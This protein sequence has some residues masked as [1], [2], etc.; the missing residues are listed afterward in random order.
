MSRPSFL[1]IGA[2]YDQIQ[3][4]FKNIVP[5]Q[6]ATL[7]S[8]LSLPPTATG[9]SAPFD[10]F[11]IISRLRREGTL[12]SNGILEELKLPGTG[13]LHG[14]SDDAVP[15][16][17]SLSKRQPEGNGPVPTC[18]LEEP[19]FPKDGTSD[20][21]SSRNAKPNPISPGG[22]VSRGISDG[23]SCATALNSIQKSDSTVRALNAAVLI[24]KGKGVYS[25][26]IAPSARPCRSRL[27][28]L[29]GELLTMIGDNLDTNSLEVLIKTETAFKRT[30]LR[31][32]LSRLGLFLDSRT[33]SVH[34]KFPTP[35]LN[36]LS[37]LPPIGYGKDSI[38][39]ECDARFVQLF[40]SHITDFVREQVNITK[41]CMKFAAND[42]AYIDWGEMAEALPQI[43][44]HLPA[45][46][47]NFA[48]S[49]LPSSLENISHPPSTMPRRILPSSL[50]TL[51]NEVTLPASILAVEAMRHVL[52]DVLTAARTQNLD[53]LGVE[54]NEALARI[55]EDL[56]TGHIRSLCLNSSVDHY[57]SIEGSTLTRFSRLEHFGFY[58]ECLITDHS[59][60]PLHLPAVQSMSLTPSF[61]SISLSG[62]SGLCSLSLSTGSASR[63]PKSPDFCEEIKQLCMLAA[64][65][66]VHSIS[67]TYPLSLM[68]WMPANL[69]EHLHEGHVAR[70]FVCR[71]WSKLYMLQTTPMTSVGSLVLDLGIPGESLCG[72]VLHP[73]TV[74]VIGATELGQF[75]AWRGGVRKANW[76]HVE[77]LVVSFDS[78]LWVSEWLYSTDIVYRSWMV[79]CNVCSSIESFLHWIELKWCPWGAPLSIQR[80]E[81]KDVMIIFHNEAKTTE[82]NKESCAHEVGRKNNAL[83][84]PRDGVELPRVQDSIPVLSCPQFARGQGWRILENYRELRYVELK[85]SEAS[86]R[87]AANDIQFELS[88]F[89]KD[90]GGLEE[91]ILLKETSEL[92]MGRIGA[93]TERRNSG[94]SSSD[95]RIPDA[96]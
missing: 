94:I 56:P 89:P 42:S 95:G 29:P 69:L 1:P 83:P 44:S 50:T 81:E 27:Q 88:A 72:G 31:D 39:L 61:S 8:H 82:S 25:R 66:G 7:T 80:C 46:C 36:Y 64:G 12:R 16:P 17:D 6:R 13:I 91:C 48:I 55:L 18:G 86:N 76:E 75:F 51:T 23:Y 21:G 28:T 93:R 4:I 73:F 22:D 79:D 40:S 34:D 52:L 90:Y 35:A 87:P 74:F 58:G 67:M 43:I 19:E 11:S 77:P 60:Y 2:D 62:W 37:E 68:L 3:R 10:R 45:S 30:L 71:C 9:S 26:P 24:A 41:F 70:R 54:S 85:L 92:D 57:I 84:L 78:C 14:R 49:R 20:S 33:L 63:D 96:V 38:T 5:L 65:L 53:I 15:T 59:P 32:Y 47:E